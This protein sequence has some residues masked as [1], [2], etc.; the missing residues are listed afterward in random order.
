VCSD[1]DPKP[2]NYNF[3]MGFFL[4]PLKVLKASDPWKLKDSVADALN[5]ADSITF[6]IVFLDSSDLQIDAESWD[7]RLRA[8]T[9]AKGYELT[10]KKRFPIGTSIG[11]PP[12]NI[13]QVVLQAQEA[14][15]G[16]SATTYAAQIDVLWSKWTLSF[17]NN[18]FGVDKDEKVGELPSPADCRKMAIEMLPGKLEKAIPSIVTILENSHFYGP[19]KGVRYI[20]VFMEAKLEIEVWQINNAAKTGFEYIVDLSFKAGD[21]ELTNAKHE[22]LRSF[23]E[24]LGWIIP[25]DI[26]KTQL[27]LTRY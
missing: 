8:S 4:D 18:K 13:P 25:A 23:L 2:A 26:L 14:G 27:I 5:V 21:L 11:T 15:F 9:D 22:A 19:V 6:E 16:G 17:S 3:E 24:T 20:G 7:V 1:P 10:Y 12:A